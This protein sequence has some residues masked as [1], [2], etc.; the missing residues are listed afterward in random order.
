MIIEDIIRQHKTIKY[1]RMQDKKRQYMQNNKQHNI[2][3]GKTRQYNTVLDK[4]NPYKT[5]HDNT[6]QCNTTS[7]RP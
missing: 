1:D 3:Q 4:V 7:Y 2:R 5:R 6:R